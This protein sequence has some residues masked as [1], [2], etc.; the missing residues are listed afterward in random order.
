MALPLHTG[1]LIISS[2]SRKSCRGYINTGRGGDDDSRYAL[3]LSP[4]QRRVT[5][6]PLFLPSATFRTW[7]LCPPQVPMDRLVWSVPLHTPNGHTHAYTHIHALGTHT[8]FLSDPRSEAELDSV[9]PP[10]HPPPL[11]KPTFFAPGELK[12]GMWRVWGV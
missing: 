8:H 7:D 6:L 12:W 1:P 10:L 5:S 3:F 11:T 9:P 2:C 4:H